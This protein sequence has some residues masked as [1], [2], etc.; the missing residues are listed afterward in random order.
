MGPAQRTAQ[1][2][3][4]EKEKRGDTDTSNLMLGLRDVLS[5]Q[6][7]DIRR[8]KSALRNS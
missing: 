2:L 3:G 5:V 1:L 7:M 6:E 8:S 4:V